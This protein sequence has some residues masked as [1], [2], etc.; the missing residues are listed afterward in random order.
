MAGLGVTTLDSPWADRL[1][2]A[3]SA[4]RQRSA[5]AFGFE[6]L[7]DLT[8]SE[9]FGSAL[10]LGFDLPEP[11]G[12]VGGGLRLVSTPAA[13]TS[14]PLGTVVV[15]S[16]SIAKA[17]FPNLYL[18]AGLDLS[19]GGNG[20][21]GWGLG[22]DLGIIQL[23]GDRGPFL[24]LRWGATLTGIG[25][26]FS[27]AKPGTG[28]LAITKDSSALPPPFT[29]TLGVESL[30]VRNENWRLG[31]SAQ[32]ALP[33]FQDLALSL[34]ANASFKNV[35]FFTTYWGF[36]LREVLL[37]A[38]TR[39]LIPSFALSAKIPIVR[40]ADASFISQRGWDR[41]EMAP[42]LIARPL[43]GSIWG[44]GASGVL[45]LGMRDLSPPVIKA[46][47]PASEWGPYYLSPN[48][49]GSHDVLAIPLTITDQRYV[50]SFDL[51]VYDGD[52]AAP[53]PASIRRTIANKETRPEAPD[54]AGLIKRLLYVQKG[55][56]VPPSLTWDG[57]SDDG[58]LVV[59]GAYTVFIDASDDNGNQAL[60]G[61]YKVI[62]DSTPPRVTISPAAASLI[63]SPDG[64]GNKDS[65]GFRFDTSHEDL[66]T[67]KILDAGGGIQRRLEY[68]DTAPTDF[69]WD[70][71]T[72]AGRVAADGVYSLVLS[73]TDRAGNQASARLDNI[74]VNTQQPPINIAIDQAFF[75]PNGDGIKDRVA[76]TTS[77]PVK[78]GVVSWRLAVIDRNK[79]ERWS[80]Q[81]PDAASL[82]SRIDFDGRDSNNSLL[83]EGQYQ[84][85]LSVFYT[86]GH[87]P[88]ALSPFFT[89]DVTPPSGSVRGDRP[90]FNPAGAE[91][92][93]RVGFTLTG[94][95][96]DRWAAS[97]YSSDPSKIPVG[98]LSPLAQ[99][100]WV[101]GSQPDPLIEWE[102][103]DDQGR[104]LPDGSYYF[105]LSSSDKAGNSFVSP[106]LVVLLD[107]EKKAVRLAADQ[108]A[109]SPNGDGVKD[110]VR[111]SDS[112][113]GKERLASFVLSLESA[114]NASSVLR[115][116]KGSSS[117][118]LLDSYVWDG[119]DSAGIKAPDGRYLARLKV[120]Y[121]NG[122]NVEAQ[123]PAIVVDTSAPSIAV[124]ASPLLFSPNGDGRLDTVALGQVSTAEDDWEGRIIGPDGAVLRSYSW[125]GQAQ[126]F[127]WDGTDEAGNT[128]KDGSYRYEVAA[129]DAAGNQGRAAIAAIVLDN[130][131]TQVLLTASETGISPNGDGFK[132][133]LKFSPIVNLREGI[134]DWN[135]SVQDKTGAEKRSFT[136]GSGLPATIDWDGRDSSGQ[137][138]QGEYTGLL[139]VG[140]LKGDR[141]SARS[142]VILV[143]TGGPIVNLSTTPPLFSPD[144][145]GVDDELSFSIAVSSVSPIDEWRLDI[146]ETAVVEGGAPGAK[147]SERN[148]I[149]WG[150][151]GVPAPS[152][153]WDGRSS[154]GELVEAATDYPYYFS[155][156][157]SLGNMT[158]VQGKLSVDVLVMKEGDRLKIKVPSI[159][160]RANYADFVGLDQET[161][162]RNSKVV[163]RIA[164][165]LNRFRDYRIVIEGNANSE[166]KIGGYSEAKIAE[167]EQ[168]ELVPLSLGRAEL[169]RSLLVQNGVDQARLSTA[170]LGSSE[171]VVDFKDSVN[172]WKN[173]RVEF[174]L[175][176]N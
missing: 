32:L 38:S 3:A 92:Q 85:S 173:R 15:A 99:R 143:D 31:A 78:A 105:Q 27:Y 101:M 75:S 82:P 58:S 76:V 140:Y 50:E 97:I 147:P 176:K 74:I 51:K 59:D 96:E 90:G 116:W 11:Y 30:F 166:G 5:L 36:D 139:T 165:I 65:L 108:R 107:T 69:T 80:S 155:I 95:R 162:D 94:S 10:A 131:P 111:I 130:R 93:N 137:V 124:N 13:M 118:A 150:G 61:P 174:V 158:K 20:S 28:L 83:P 141:P 55:V 71:K 129:T 14:L 146:G 33:S 44:L 57:R 142:S 87:S 100:T 89:L 154:K 126:G 6:G 152:I 104:P 132:D 91:G 7:A 134:A 168:K 24:D 106:P 39:S 159:V 68:R 157:D 167:E 66:W 163:K 175:I 115:T 62:V 84:A 35:V 18:G 42:T 67:L 122:D 161:L 79:V 160:F 117:A 125:K 22:L 110:S 54:F 113:L 138:L 26:G 34:S 144:N 37:A 70:G 121:Q 148:F 170:G 133:S 123:S 40:K 102:G 73:S 52:L 47:F 56:V 127:T 169:V 45:T 64:D 128:V 153:V 109:F 12:V 41:S 21:F 164:Q 53:A 63:F 9:G 119:L 156:R 29:P 23:L 16:G 151:K 8:G 43:Y 4:G 81:G 17:L 112:V 86:N 77:V 136:G 46:D 171:P 48:S 135:L 120:A 25:K 98:G 172:R 49:D 19:L 103:S 88:H 72:D 114:D 1:N 60:A 149:S 2:P 145:D